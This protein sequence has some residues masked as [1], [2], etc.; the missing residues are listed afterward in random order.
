MIWMP[1]VTQINSF[2]KQLILFKRAFGFVISQGFVSFQEGIG[3]VSRKAFVTMPS[4]QQPWDLTA[5]T[6]IYFP[7]ALQVR[8]TWA[9]PTEI[10]QGLMASTC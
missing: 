10:Y 2:T 5:R 4:A 7:S 9:F 1:L 3:K 8:Y 6:D